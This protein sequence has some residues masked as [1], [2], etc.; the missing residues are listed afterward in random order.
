MYTKKIRKL[1]TKNGYSDDD[2]LVINLDEMK[3]GDTV[4]AHLYKLTGRFLFFFPAL[5]TYYNIPLSFSCLFLLVIRP[6]FP[7]LFVVFDFLPP[8]SSFSK[9]SLFLLPFLYDISFFLSLLFLSFTGYTSSRLC[10]SAF[11]TVLPSFVIHSQVL[12]FF[13]GLPSALL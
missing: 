6:C 12:S 2:A 3:A 9:L 8:L 7:R 11:S 1:I 4:L 5:L 10:Q 13:S